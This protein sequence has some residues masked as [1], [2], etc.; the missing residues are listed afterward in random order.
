MEQLSNKDK[1]ELFMSM[2]EK[3][4]NGTLESMRMTNTKEYDRVYSQLRNNIGPFGLVVSGITKDGKIS[5]Y[6]SDQMTKQI[7][8]NLLSQSADLKLE[9]AQL[10]ELLD[11][12]YD[13]NNMQILN[14]FFKVE[15]DYL[16]TISLQ[17]YRDDE[18]NGFFDKLVML[19]ALD[20]L[21]QQP[22]SIDGRDSYSNEDGL[23]LSLLD[24][25]G[26][27][28]IA[29]QMG[30]EIS[31]YDTEDIRKG[32]MTTN[33]TSNPQFKEYISTFLQS[34]EDLPKV[35]EAITNGTYKRE[36]FISTLNSQEKQTA[37]QQKESEL[38]TLEA[39]AKTIS[40]AEALIDRQNEGQNIGE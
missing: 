10:S 34:V 35:Y 17:E 2:V 39:E 9:E 3:A 30:D 19:N 36:D 31:I 4:K 37:L 23:R 7:P 8:T 28:Y 6:L 26:K 32:T 25:K 33:E 16:K 5:V 21:S 15:P 20:Y 12:F 27:T 14:E 24:K 22:I 11:N 38:S 18:Y 40:E 13:M 29:L 1:K